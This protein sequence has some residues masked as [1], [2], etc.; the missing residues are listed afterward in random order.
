MSQE[1]PLGCLQSLQWSL[2]SHPIQ[3]FA[4]RGEFVLGHALIDHVP[5]SR[6]DMTEHAPIDS[7][8][9]CVSTGSYILTYSYLAICMS[10]L[11]LTKTESTVKAM[12][13]NV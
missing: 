1:L 8:G 5:C 2:G 3:R 6:E 12:F 7:P 13:K 10:K 4:A 9:R 11:K